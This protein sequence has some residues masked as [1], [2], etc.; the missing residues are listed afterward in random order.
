M[1]Q[2]AEPSATTCRHA[3][4]ECGALEPVALDWQ[5]QRAPGSEGPAAQDARRMCRLLHHWTKLTVPV[6]HD[7]L[8]PGESFPNTLHGWRFFTVP[9]R[10]DHLQPEPNRSL[11]DQWP[12]DRDYHHA[13]YVLR[14]DLT[15]RSDQRYWLCL[16]AVAHGCVAFFNGVEVGRHV[17]GYTPFEFDISDAAQSGENT[18][19]IWVRDETAILDHTQQRATGQVDK[20]RGN[21]N[22]HFAGIRGGVYLETRAAAHVARIRVRPSTRNRTL[23]VETWLRGRASD[24]RIKH[25]VYE[26]PR[27]DTPVLELPEQRVDAAPDADPPRID[28]SAA[29][30]APR[31]WSPQHPNLYVLRTTVTANGRS[32]SIDTRF[33]FREFWIEGG[34]FMLNGKPIRLFGDGGMPQE[35]ASTVPDVAR[36]Y[37]RRALEFLKQHFNF[38]STRLHGMTFPAWATQAADEAGVLIIDQSGLRQGRMRWYENCLDTFLCNVEQEFG[39][40][41]WRD[42]NS[43]S[44][45]IWDVENELIRGQRTPAREKWVLQL[46]E[47]IRKHDPDAIIEHSGAAWYK[48]D[49]QIIHV[50]MQEQYNRVMRTWLANPHAPL[51]LG[52]FWMGGRGETRLPNGYEY[53]DREDWHTEE[54]RLY[55]EQMLEMRNFGVFGIMPHR[56]LRWPLRTPGPLWSQADCDDLESKQF[57]WRFSEDLKLGG[58]GLAPIVSF[59]WPRGATVVDGE[60]FER[61]VVVC[62][63]SED[64][65]TLTVTSEYGSQSQNWQVALDPAEQRRFAIRLTPEADAQRITVSVSDEN[66]QHIEGDELPIHVIPAAATRHARTTRRLVVVPRIDDETE[67]AL[68]ELGAAYTVSETLPTDAEQ[69]IVIV[70]PGAQSDALGATSAAVAQYLAAGG[71]LLALAQTAAPDWLPLEMPFCSAVRTSVPEFDRG[72]WD[73]TNKDLIYTRELQPYSAAHSVLNELQT[74]DF[75]EWSPVDGRISDDVFVRPNAV[76]MRA[77]GVYRV[78]LGATRRENASLI[79]FKAG[80]GTGVLCQAQVLRQRDH[81]AAR[82]MLCNVLRYLDGPAWQTDRQTVGVMGEVSTKRLHALTGIDEACFKTI[83]D[84][85]DAPRFIVA[86]DNADTQLMHQ[87][88]DSGATVLVLSCETCSRMTGYALEQAE[89]AYYSGT[90]ANI[91]DHPLFWGVASASF[92]PLEKTP[93]RGALAQIPED[94]RILLGGHGHGHS[95]FMNDWSVDIGFYGLETREPAPPIAAVQHI[96]AGEIIATTIEPWDH[97]AE[98]HR[99]LLA[100]LFA[101]AGVAIPDQ[102]GRAQTITIKPTVPLNFDG[103]LDDWTNDMED[104]NLSVHSHADPI[105]LRS[106]DRHAGEVTGDLDLSAI[107]YLLHDAEH[108]YIAGIVFTA[109]DPGVLTVD[110]HSHAIKVDAASQAVQLDGQAFTSPSFAVG[111]QPA[112]EIIDARLLNLTRAHRQTG[113]VERFPDTPARTFELAIPWRQ[114]GYNQPPAQLHGRFTLTRG[115]DVLQRPIGDKG[116]T[117]HVLLQ[118][119]DEQE[120]ARYTDWS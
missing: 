83:T 20:G 49:Q 48:P 15:P 90:R 17:G 118:V 2:L 54:A 87:L 31:L 59:V 9:P 76:N 103:R 117:Q 105:T 78:L 53:T 40:W 62:N 72:G 5:P 61:E 3:V 25:A 26:W 16:D 23:S 107:A 71:R 66:G 77:A 60:P 102:A 6:A 92:L 7:H 73:S 45:V 80:E 89:D 119:Q 55:R 56:L 10:R 22:A 12:P 38:M 37:G 52:E 14:F 110:L 108:L 98:T 41:Y 70:P 42:V 88:A 79:E 106:T 32:E 115:D 93:V 1:Q 111:E 13:W 116:Q 68:E 58:R 86:G 27:G 84:S 8:E 21:Y 82:A 109:G 36:V 11:P 95:P 91:E 51:N 63:D 34:R 96:G 112:S 19:A 43:P 24:I 94:A 81:P 120:D 50:H 99:Q 18:L 44:V 35:L 46:D 100:N 57:E 64:Q 29:W 113:K 97:D 75:K 101:N 85:R 114:L 4:D 67:N 74:C 28:S 104:I 39:E 30:H 65:R 33:G 47:F 69:T